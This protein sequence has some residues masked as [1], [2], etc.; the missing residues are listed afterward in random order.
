MIELSF[1][2]RQPPACIQG[3]EVDPKARFPK[4]GEEVVIV[5]HRVFGKRK[6]LKGHISNVY[7][8][9]GNKRYYDVEIRQE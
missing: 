6:V 8:G 2:W 4:M 5:Q 7:Y 3:I 1:S 9:L